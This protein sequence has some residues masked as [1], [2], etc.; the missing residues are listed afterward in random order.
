MTSVIPHDF[1]VALR[2]A[3]CMSPR[4]TH[5]QDLLLLWHG[6]GSFISVVFTFPVDLFKFK[7]Y[8]RFNPL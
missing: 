5:G 2:Y 7:S 4:F 6:L 3:C 8:Q 1:V